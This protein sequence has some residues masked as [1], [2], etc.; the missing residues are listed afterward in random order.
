MKCLLKISSYYRFVICHCQHPVHKFNGFCFRVYHPYCDLTI[1]EK[2]HFPDSTSH[3][4]HT[5]FFGILAIQISGDQRKI[6]LFVQL[7][8]DP[9][10]PGISYAWKY[11]FGMCDSHFQS[12][13]HVQ[14]Y[15][16]IASIFIEILLSFIKLCFSALEKRLF[17]CLF[18]TEYFH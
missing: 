6:R 11:L 10:L 17:H 5:Q 12:S 8:N 18:D 16:Q 4:H 15:V 9:Q 1:L 3:N 13:L 2:V 7:R 14:C